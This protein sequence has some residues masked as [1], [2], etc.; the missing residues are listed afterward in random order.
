MDIVILLI[1]INNVD[2]II[3]FGIILSLLIDD[4]K[5][6][7][8]LSINCVLFNHID[9]ILYWYCWYCWYCWYYLIK[10]GEVVFVMCDVVCIEYCADY[11]FLLC[12]MIVCVLCL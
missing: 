11:L 10:G 2:L 8:L 1:I 4:I 7:V 12:I 9:I 5:Y 3:I 6:D